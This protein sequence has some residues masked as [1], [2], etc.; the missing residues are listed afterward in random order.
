MNHGD[1][2]KFFEY[3]SEVVIIKIDQDRCEIHDQDQKRIKYFGLK[4]P[5]M[6]TT[7]AGDCLAAGCRAFIGEFEIK[8][9]CLSWLTV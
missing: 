6:V 2:S 1:I 9:I 4:M 5:V 3:D 7:I 8:K